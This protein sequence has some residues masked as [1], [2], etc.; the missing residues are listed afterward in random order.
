MAGTGIGGK[1]AGAGTSAT[2]AGSGSATPVLPGA[3]F[4]ADTWEELHQACC[5]SASLRFRRAYSQPAMP[6]IASTAP[7]SQGVH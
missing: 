2:G 6:S 1:G 3:A 5:F 4:A 7:S